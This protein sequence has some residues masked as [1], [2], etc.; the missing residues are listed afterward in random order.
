MFDYNC[1]YC[2][3]A[4][5]DI[6]TLLAED[7]KLKLILKEFPI[8][9]PGSIEAAKVAALVNEDKSLDYWAFHQKLFSMRGQIGAEQ[10]LEAAAAVGAN[11][12]A[13]MI[14]MNGKAAEEAVQRGYRLATALDVSGTPTFIIGDEII[15]GAVGLAALREKIANMRACG[16]TVCAADG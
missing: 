12:V 2:R 13:L 9:S 4:L 15:P 14:D 16:S 6:A 7:P 5:P 1:T 8:L 3:Q 11:R 10:A